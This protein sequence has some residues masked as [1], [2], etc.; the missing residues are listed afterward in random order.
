M[1]VTKS[2]LDVIA[3]S[4]IITFANGAGNRVDADLVNANFATFLAFVQTITNFLIDQSPQT[5]VATTYTAA[6]TFNAELKTDRVQSTTGT[7]TVYLG[8]TG[9]AIGD[10]IADKDYVNFQIAAAGVISLNY[11][12]GGIQ[13][14]T[15]TPIKGFVYAINTTSAGFS[16]TLPSAP[17]EGDLI[18][19]VDIKGTFGINNFTIGRNGKTIMDLSEDLIVNTRYAA[20]YLVYSAVAG[21]WYFI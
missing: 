3:S 20:V 7:D 9:S 21:G 6:Q 16:V 12:F 17:S 18:G 4:D 2:D 1:V 15:F 19:F 13:A 10:Q 14:S 5:G 8:A 11:S